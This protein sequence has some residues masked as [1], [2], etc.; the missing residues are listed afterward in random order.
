MTVKLLEY[1]TSNDWMEVKRRALVT[2]GKKSIA[3][4]SDEWKRDIL[5]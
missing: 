4:P 3:P 5:R 1:P 2:I